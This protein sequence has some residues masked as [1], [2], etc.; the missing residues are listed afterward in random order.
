VYVRFES[1]L[2]SNPRSS[3]TMSGISRRPGNGGAWYRS[4]MDKVAVLVLIAVAA[5]VSSFV[6]TS[7]FAVRPLRRRWLSTS[8]GV[9][10]ADFAEKRLRPIGRTARPNGA[11]GGPGRVLVSAP[12]AGVARAP[13]EGVAGSSPPGWLSAPEKCPSTCAFVLALVHPTG[14]YSKKCPQVD[15]HV[16]RL[17]AR[18]A[19]LRREGY[20]RGERR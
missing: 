9:P 18:H 13:I 11:V 2:R 3:R 19:K 1:V 5:F 16:L 14:Q 12:P 17:S 4:G 15:G 7:V 10:L 20:R 8:A 6:L